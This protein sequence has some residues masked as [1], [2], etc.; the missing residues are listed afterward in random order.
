VPRLKGFKPLNGK[1]GATDF[2]KA[3]S[4]AGAAGAEVTFAIVFPVDAKGGAKDAFGACTSKLSVIREDNYFYSSYIIEN[5]PPKSLSP[6]KF[7]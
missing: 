4:G 7:R 3:N 6:L 2:E 5:A 1:E